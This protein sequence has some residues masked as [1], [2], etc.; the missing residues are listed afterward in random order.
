MLLVAASLSALYVYLFWGQ[1][2]FPD[3][4]GALP[5]LLWL[6]LVVAHIAL[7][8]FALSISAAIRARLMATVTLVYGL[9]FVGSQTWVFFD[10][11][12]WDEKLYAAWQA[13]FS[14]LDVALHAELDRDN[15]DVE[16]V[17]E[18]LEDG[19]D[20]DSWRG[21]WAIWKAYGSGEPDLV[22]LLISHG[23]GVDRYSRSGTNHKAMVYRVDGPMERLF[24]GRDQR[25][26]LLCEEIVG[27]HQSHEGLLLGTL[28]RAGA[29]PD[30]LCRA[31]G[32]HP[33]LRI[34]SDYRDFSA[35]TALTQ[36]GAKT[37]HPATRAALRE[38]LVRACRNEDL[39]ML[40]AHAA[41]L[42]V[43]EHSEAYAQGLQHAVLAGAT[44]S[45]RRM[46]A[47]GAEP[48]GAD[49]IF[50]AVR[51]KHVDT[52]LFSELAAL[53]QDPNFVPGN[54]MTSMDTLLEAKNIS[55]F[56]H[57]IS[58]G[59]DVNSSKYREGLLHRTFRH[60]APVDV[61]FARAILAAGGDVEARDRNGQTFLMSAAYRGDLPMVELAL[62]YGAN[63]M[64]TTR[65]GEN[66]GQ[67][68]LKNNHSDALLKLLGVTEP[69]P[70][71]GGDELVYAAQHR[72]LDRVVE[73]LDKGVDV[74][75]LN[76]KGVSALE[77]AARKDREGVYRL[78]MSRGADVHQTIEDGSPL[79]ASNRTSW[80][81]SVARQRALEK[82]ESRAIPLLAA[83]ALAGKASLVTELVGWGA[84]PNVSAASRGDLPLHLV[85]QAGRNREATTRALIAGGATL[86]AQNDAGY[87]PSTLAAKH[88]AID[89][90]RVLA[91]L[92]CDLNEADGQGRTVLGET[93]RAG[94]R[95]EH[96]EVLAELGVR[97]TQR[98]LAYAHAKA[99]PRVSE[100]L[101]SM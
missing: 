14:P 50:H 18:L 41:L 6:V 93:L 22:D 67:L 40:D 25:K 70:Q 7:L 82:G 86:N 94:S 27:R 66:A 69:R 20:A 85:A 77:V 89:M 90:I 81:A 97:V 65:R 39:S 10:Y 23:A 76:R 56:E 17:S 44:Q 2:H 30:Q 59:A 33:A 49:L 24:K 28:L 47:L 96:L 15:P 35:L 51:N 62:E 101:R 61:M 79:D 9:L 73:L 88:N 74:N 4:Q 58:L 75:A 5:P 26:T 43:T 92:G 95:Q 11:M 72:P 64:A 8:A 78:L 54:D 68:A 83:A 38:G 53:G 45:A 31:A 37:T 21:T 63:Q 57:L 52:E 99:S 1:I 16:R 29:D 13:Q 80:A 87:L 46:I 71:P 32:R 98:D 3:F 60:D 91:E 42:P 12:M 84:K 19:A 48:D 36:H 55:L 34:A 100:F